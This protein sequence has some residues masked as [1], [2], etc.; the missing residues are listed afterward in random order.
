MCKKILMI[1]IEPTPYI[2]GLIL[3]LEIEWRGEIDVLFLE[4]NHS[5]QWNIDL[6]KRW[7]IW[8][9]NFCE[10]IKFIYRI[11]Y[12]K[13]YK[14]IHIAG[15]GR[16]LLILFIF[17]SK[18]SRTPI[19]VES[20]TTIPYKIQFW[21]KLIKRFLYPKLFN[22]VNLFLPGGTRQAKYLQYYG[23][24]SSKIFSVQMTVDVKNIKKFSSR[25]HKHDFLKIRKHYHLRENDHVFLFVGRL[26]PHKGILDLISAF[27]Q[28][29]SENVQLMIAGDGPLR[30]FVE[31]KVQHNNKIHYAG[32][33]IHEQLL[34]MYYIASVVVLPS[35]F[36]PWGLV[37][38]EAMAVGRPVIV[39]DRVGCIDDLIIHRKNGWIFK[40][41]C[42]K[43]LCT[44]MEYFVEK[45]DHRLLM[46]RESTKIIA[47]WTLENEAKKIC[48]A[49]NMLVYN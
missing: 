36:E 20:D 1:Y 26:V 38:N 31:N 33:L 27:E 37:V 17:I 12:K 24:N 25:L 35:H 22:S 10:K 39:S 14:S 15:W 13:K 19:I 44:A 8:P 2:I 30:E 11:F 28:L 34:E 4:K 6:N 29:T 18:L 32:R 3:S 47:E 21:K 46:G 5:Q 40:A 41:E 49:W 23:V 16:L 9:N 42:V 43:D 7:G 45:T 48:K